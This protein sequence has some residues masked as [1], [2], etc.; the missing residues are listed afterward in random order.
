MLFRFNL[1]GLVPYPSVV[2]G[3]SVHQFHGSRG[4]SRKHPLL[5]FRFGPFSLGRVL[6]TRVA[7]TDHG[8]IDSVA[9]PPDPPTTLPRTPVPLQTLTHQLNRLPHPDRLPRRLPP[10]LGSRPERRWECRGVEETGGDTGR[11]VGVRGLPAPRTAPL[12]PDAEEKGPTSFPR[13]SSQTR[14]RAS[15]PRPSFQ[16]SS[17]RTRS[18]LSLDP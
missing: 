12:D 7:S 14:D 11:A 1:N 4:P 17:F 15:A 6:G 9:K 2:Y 5:F 8:G 3:V 10:C 13:G 16:A 18:R